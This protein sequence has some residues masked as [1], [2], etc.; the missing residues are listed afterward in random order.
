MKKAVLLLLALCMVLAGCGGGEPDQI[1]APET[2]PA[3]PGVKTVY[4]HES[5][6]RTDTAGVHRTQYV[7]N[8][9]NILSGVV[10]YDGQDQE[11]QRYQVVCDEYG[12]PQEWTTS[13]EGM[14]SSIAYRFD[15]QGHTLGTYAYSGDTLVTSTE[16]TWSGD[17]RISN[18]VKAVAQNFEQRIEYTYDEN[19]RL[20]R[21]DQYSNGELSAYAI[22][23]CDDQ[24]RL[25]SSKAY[26]L[27]GNHTSTIASTYDGS[28]ETRVTTQANGVVV[29][30]QTMTY[31][32][33][34]NLLTSVFTDG[35]GNTL[36]SETHTWI[37]IE[38]PEDS[39]RASI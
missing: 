6:T 17:L 3:A 20:I 39:P 31:D 23:T 15:N 32:D 24:G 28:T 30:T 5:I 22:C 14:T 34:G 1:Q 8:E 11:V 4:V 7:Y 16:Y 29:Q 2:T 13:M 35:E 12:N 19:Q 10:I 21:Q 38:V 33:A 25:I 27:E 18:T 9:K 26:D 37:A 36:S